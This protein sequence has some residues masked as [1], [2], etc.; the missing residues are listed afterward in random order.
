[1]V[2]R[3][4]R[5]EVRR[6]EAKIV[7]ER[8]A[9]MPSSKASHSGAAQRAR[10]AVAQ[11]RKALQEELGEFRAG[12]TAQERR[13]STQFGRTS[14]VSTRGQG[15]KGASATLADADADRR[16]ARSEVERRGGASLADPNADR[17]VKVNDGGSI[18]DGPRAGNAAK[19]G[20]DAKG[21]ALTRRQYERVQALQAEAAALE[22]KQV[23]TPEEERRLAQIREQVAGVTKPGER[24]PEVVVD[25]NAPQAQAQVAAGGGAA[26]AVPIQRSERE[27]ALEQARSEEQRAAEPAAEPE[28]DRGIYQR[29]FGQ[30]VKVGEEGDVFQMRFGQAVKVG[31]EGDVFQKRFGVIEKVG[32]KGDVFQVRL[33]RA[34]KVGQEGDVFQKRFGR[35]ERVGTADDQFIR[36]LG[37]WVRAADAR[38]PIT[39]L[40]TTLRANEILASA[41]AAARRGRLARGVVI[42]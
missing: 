28:P 21:K 7:R 26:G 13:A 15:M 10:V 9:A 6:Q 18:V 23:R 12:Q 5:A 19:Y 25:P 2:A 1:V 39:R 4:E 30:V 38:P 8:E 35:Y 22:A 3:Q 17:D 16:D 34:E 29:Q 33:G 42:P 31:V 40:R 24:L 27:Q 11:N 20:R 41:R 36:Q 32:G 14:K 37:G